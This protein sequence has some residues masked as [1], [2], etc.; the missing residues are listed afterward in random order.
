MSC[1]AWL[2]SIKSILSDFF[3]CSLDT[4]AGYKIGPSAPFENRRQ[5]R[6]GG[7]LHS[8]IVV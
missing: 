8:G 5:R 4:P 7:N 2:E 3:V 1:E 6:P